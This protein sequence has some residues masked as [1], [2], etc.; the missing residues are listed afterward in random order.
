[1]KKL[2][3][4]RFIYFNGF[5]AQSHSVIGKWKTIDDE[6]AKQ[7]QLWKFTSVPKLWQNCRYCRC[8]EKFVLH[9]LARK[10][11]K[12]VMGLVIIKG[13]KRR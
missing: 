13:L 6:T 1:M 7:N 9:A 12:P 3:Q 5:Y 8:R 10:K 11:N 4:F 2:L